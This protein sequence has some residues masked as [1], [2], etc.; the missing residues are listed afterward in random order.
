M[1]VLL[2]ICLFFSINSFAQKAAWDSLDIQYHLVQSDYRQNETIFKIKLPP[3]LTTHQVMQQIKLLVKFPT[4]P[5]PTKRVKVYVY[6]DDAIKGASSATG[7]IYIP[8]KGYKWDLADWQ[9]DT[10]IFNYTPNNQD[11]IIYNTLLDSLFAHGIYAFSMEDQNLP[12]KKSVAKQFDLTLS[13]LD[14]IYYKVKWWQKINAS[15]KK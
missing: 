10:S 13:A 8:S 9:P 5:K 12:T 2:S 4:S 7:G 1:R 15:S 6:R 11:K 3:Y 14:S